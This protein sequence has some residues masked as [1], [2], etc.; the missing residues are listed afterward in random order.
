MLE[1]TS[2]GKETAPEQW[3]WVETT[4][5]TERMLAALENGV[6]GGKWFSLM[7]KVYRMDTLRSAWQQ[8]RR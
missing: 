5:W 6:K 4:I 7:D 3:S 2:P 8:V 1:T